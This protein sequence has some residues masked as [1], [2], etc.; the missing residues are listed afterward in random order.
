MAGKGRRSGVA[1]WGGRNFGFGS[2]RARPSLIA[3]DHESIV[4]L[5]DEA[6]RVL[7]WFAEEDKPV[8]FV[9]WYIQFPDKL[10]HEFG[11][12]SNEVSQWTSESVQ[13]S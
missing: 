5:I 6:D 8:N 2:M 12:N 4:P 7:E 1:F 3:N 13:N 10:A 9:A 11:P